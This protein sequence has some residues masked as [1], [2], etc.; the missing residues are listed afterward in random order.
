MNDF[1]RRGGPPRDLFGGGGPNR[2]GPPNQGP[3][4][5]PPLGMMRGGVA[6]G[7]GGGGGMGGPP[8][9]GQRMGG[10]PMFMRG[11][12]RGASGSGK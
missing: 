9:F 8:P 4:G 6:G 11:N 10:S 7:N 1:D 2:F 3:R 5:I 12:S